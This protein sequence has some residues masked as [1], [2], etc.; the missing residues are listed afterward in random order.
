ME[1][2]D[3]DITLSASTGTASITAGT[4]GTTAST[5]VYTI[6]GTTAGNTSLTI[7][8]TYAVSGAGDI[9]DPSG[10]EM[11]DGETVS[12]IDGAAPAILIASTSDNDSDGTIDRLTLTFSETV[13]IT[14]G[15]RIMI[16]LYRPRQAQQVLL[17]ATMELRLVLWFIR[18]VERRQ[19]IPP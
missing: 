8:P 4:Y 3:D 9:T 15:G 19:I 5:L 7:T 6:N 13:V 11:S 17:Q 10:N 14:D 1:V 2:T 18:S 16:L 12:G